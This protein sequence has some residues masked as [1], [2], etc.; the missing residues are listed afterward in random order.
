[1]E[2]IAAAMLLAVLAVIAMLHDRYVERRA[3]RH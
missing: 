1:M 3:R 2:M